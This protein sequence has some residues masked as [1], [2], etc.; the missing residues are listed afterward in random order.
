VPEYFTPLTL[1][2]QTGVVSTEDTGG[3]WGTV[4]EEVMEKVRGRET[5]SERADSSMT[6]E[7]VGIPQDL[8]DWEGGWEK[9]H[10]QTGSYPSE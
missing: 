7:T 10:H 9:D 5:R 6:D 3:I 1:D 4:K 2:L 8:W